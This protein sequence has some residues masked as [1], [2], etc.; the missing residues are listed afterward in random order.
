MDTTQTTPERIRSLRRAHNLSREALAV[1]AGVSGTVVM[2]AE[3]GK[4]VGVG[5]LVRMLAVLD[6]DARVTDLADH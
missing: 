6:P 3:Q 4:R 5:S 2:R 1:K